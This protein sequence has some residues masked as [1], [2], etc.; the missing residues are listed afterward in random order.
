MT[1]LDAVLYAKSNAILVETPGDHI[2]QCPANYKYLFRWDGA[3]LP[4]ANMFD[5]FGDPTDSPDKAHG[6]CAFVAPGR[7]RW[8]RDCTPDEFIPRE[9]VTAS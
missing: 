6:V 8:A 9:K 7:W 3:W 4:V 2:N 1:Q 5:V